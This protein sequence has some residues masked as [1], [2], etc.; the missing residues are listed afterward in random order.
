MS[1]LSKIKRALLRAD[2]DPAIAA[3]A[4]PY[5]PPL[6]SWRRVAEDAALAMMALAVL[7]IDLSL[8]VAV[9]S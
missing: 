6:R 1:A 9:L 7:W 4:D 5:A 2:T 3:W 8:L